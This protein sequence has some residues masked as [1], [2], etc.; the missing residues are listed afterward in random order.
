M[1]A[2]SFG[3]G[4]RQ[5]YVVMLPLRTL[6]EWIVSTAHARGARTS[7][8]EIRDSA[9]GWHYMHGSRSLGAPGAE[10]TRLRSQGVEI[11]TS[12]KA[13]R[14]IGSRLPGFSTPN[15]PSVSV[16]TLCFVL[17]R[18]TSGGAPC[19]HRAS[20]SQCSDC[21]LGP[22]LPTNLKALSSPLVSN[23]VPSRTA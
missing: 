6:G 20:N 16:H 11:S 17:D 23:R 14:A 22:S 8:S 12:H 7:V 18:R 2:R 4:D 1:V 9:T 19:C 10:M 3:P 5:R 15:G 21:L 13:F